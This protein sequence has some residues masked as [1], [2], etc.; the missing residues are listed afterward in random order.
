MAINLS[1]QHPDYV[2]TAG[3]RRKSRDLYE[4]GDAVKA[5]GK[6]YLYREKNETDDDYAL[7]LKRAVLDP[8]VGKIVGARQA[9]LFQKPVERTLPTRLAGWMEDVDRKGTRADTFFADAARDA[10]VDGVH[11]VLVDMPRLE[12]PYPSAQFERQAGHRPFFEHVPGDAV[13]DWEVGP[14]QALLWAVVAQ[15][16]AALRP[17]AGLSAPH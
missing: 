12:A 13:I 3:A 9:L 8:Y 5:R 11:W 17:L 15:Q 16:T 2:A 14:D 4:G 7:R 6:E 1:N 10:Q